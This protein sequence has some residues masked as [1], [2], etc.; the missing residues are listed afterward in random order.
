MI[1]LE[2]EIAVMPAC[3]HCG[4]RYIPVHQNQKKFCGAECR[5][6]VNRLRAIV[7]SAKYRQQDFRFSLPG[8]GCHTPKVHVGTPREDNGLKPWRTI[9]RDLGLSPTCCRKAYA[10]ALSKL[11]ERAPWLARML[12]PEP[13][14]P[15]VRA[16]NGRGRRGR[17]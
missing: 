14:W 10:S 6:E 5:A 7:N 11:K 17:S 12:A 8:D 2:I 13:A 9:G 3:A 16:L 4:I 1:A 15:G